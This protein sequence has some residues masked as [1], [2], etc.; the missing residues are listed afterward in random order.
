MFMMVLAETG[1]LGFLAFIALLFA[2]FKNGLRYFNTCGDSKKKYFSLSLMAG[3]IGI[4]F[5]MLTYDLLYWQT[6]F[7]LFWLFAG[8]IASFNIVSSGATQYP[9]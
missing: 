8:I 1:I 9:R 7:Y 6:P 4:L 3:L 5:N 2:L